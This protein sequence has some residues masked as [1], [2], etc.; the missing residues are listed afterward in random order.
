M[1][2]R[3]SSR[4]ASAVVAPFTYAVAHRVK[5]HLRTLFFFSMKIYVL[6]LVSFYLKA[7]NSKHVS[8]PLRR[9]KGADEQETFVFDYVFDNA[10]PA[11]KIIIIGKEVAFD[12]IKQTSY[13]PN[14]NCCVKVWSFTFLSSKFFNDYIT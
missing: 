5:S 6:W 1:F 9:K 14:W 12:S 4:F 8:T 13:S 2:V 10:T 3:Q 11:R 7:I